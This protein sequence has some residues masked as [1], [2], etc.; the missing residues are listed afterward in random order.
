MHVQIVNYTEDNENAPRA[1]LC[2][3]GKCEKTTLDFVCSNVSGSQAGWANGWRLELDSV[4]NKVSA[5]RNGQVFKSK[6]LTCKE[7]DKE[8][9]P[10]KW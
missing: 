3:S 10:L 6:D 2:V 5:T 7:I 8:A 9:C 1:M 4:R